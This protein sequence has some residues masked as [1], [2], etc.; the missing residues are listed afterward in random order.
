MAYVKK[1]PESNLGRPSKYNSSN[2][3]KVEKLCKLGAT[4]EEIAD[5][6]DVAVSTIY[7][8]KLKEPDFSESIKKGKLVADMEVANSL[9]KRALGYSQKVDKVFQFQGEPVI[10]PTLE[11]IPPDTA[12]AFIWLKNRRPKQF[13]D[14]QEIEMSGQLVIFGGEDNLE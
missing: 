3:E 10:V 6:F 5:F 2:N 4:D 11:H 12:A 9:H 7:E 1:Q 8:W 13:K 14:K